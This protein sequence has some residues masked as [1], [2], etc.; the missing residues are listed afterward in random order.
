MEAFRQRLDERLARLDPSARRW[1]LVLPDGLTD[2]VGPLADGEPGGLAAVLVENRWSARRRPYHRQKLALLWSNLRHF[3]LEQASRGVWVEYVVADEP[4]RRAVRRVAETRGPLVAMTP[5][6]RELRCDLAPLV[7]DGCLA[8]V[9]HAGWLTT[10]DQFDA[11]GGPPW[12]MDAFYRRVRRE[13]GLLM[14]DGDPVGGTFSFDSENREPWHGDP[15]APDPPGFDVGPVKREVGDLIE[16][17]F[18][19]HPGRLDLEALPATREDAEA[20]WSWARRKCLPHFGPYEDAMSTAS[21][22]LFHTRVSSLVNLGRLLPRHLIEDTVETD[23][24]LAS[25]E[26]FLR[27]VIGWREFV[28]HVHEATDGFRD[29]PGEAGPSRGVADV[30]GDAGYRT[31]SGKPWRGPKR[32]RW[33]DGGAAP[34]ALGDATPLPPAYWGEFSGLACLDT[35]VEDVWREGWSHHIT[36]L[37]VLSNLASLLDASPRELTDWF[38]IAYTDAWDWVVEPN[39]LAMGTFAVGDLMTTK[40]Y[41]S[42]APYVH[43]MSDFCEGCAFDPKRDCPIT[44]LYWAF[45]ARHKAALGDVPRMNLVMASLRK[46]PAAKRRID[47]EVFEWATRT[48]GAAEPLRPD[49]R[50]GA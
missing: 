46:R 33:L 37:M 13:T 9:P 3:A 18:A 29:L 23:A 39:V 38:W 49:D 15:P 7:A 34:A 47:A 14:E 12:R 19:R 20:L 11:A 25:R 26:G 2:R 32:L 10:R 31:W 4:Y 43:R 28:R 1:V 27:Q 5:A 22:G 50:P 35:V 45:L 42:G 40:P 30:P 41:V 24:P 48:L 21:T 44:D 36:R 8:Y 6:E 16:S 17:E